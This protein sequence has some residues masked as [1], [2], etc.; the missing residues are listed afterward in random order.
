[1]GNKTTLNRNRVH[2]CV[3][4]A[5]LGTPKLASSLTFAMNVSFLGTSSPEAR[6]V[7]LP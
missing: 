5:S 4:H 2:E 6:S 1:M 7:C 3:G